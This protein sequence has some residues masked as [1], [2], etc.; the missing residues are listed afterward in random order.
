M[1]EIMQQVYEG[2]PQQTSERKLQQ[3]FEGKPE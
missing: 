3:A 1:K 2:K